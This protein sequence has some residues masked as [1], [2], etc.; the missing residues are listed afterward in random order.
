MHNRD[1]LGNIV[2]RLVIGQVVSQ[3]PVHFLPESSYQ[4]R[5]GQRS[6]DVPDLSTATQEDD[7]NSICIILVHIQNCVVVL[8]LYYVLLQLA[9]L[10]LLLLPLPP[11]HYYH[12]YYKIA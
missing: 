11:Y 4:L 10:L 7:L 8:L 9:L 1:L 12:Y 3:Q 5:V 6:G 2:S